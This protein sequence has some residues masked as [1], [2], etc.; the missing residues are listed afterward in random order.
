M[1][2]KCPECELKISS[3]A[4]S[5]PHCGY[6]LRGSRPEN[7]KQRYNPST[8][9]KRLPNG[10]GQISFIKGNLRNPFRAM[11]TVG[12]N[13]SGR[14][15]CKPLKPK[16]YFAT[17][18]DAYAALVEYNKNPY[19]MD[20]S[21]T[22][23]EL[24]NKW[25]D[26]Y[27]ED[28]KSSAAKAIDSAWKYCSEIYDYRVK[29]LRSRHIK[30][31]MENGT[32]NI[33]GN[34]K[35]TPPSVRIRIKSLF[36]MMLDYAVE[37][38]MVEKNCAK[39]FKISKE[40]QSDIVANRKA[41]KAFTDAEMNILWDNAEFGTYEDMILIQ[42][43]S[44]WRPNEL[45]NMRIENVNINEWTFT[46]GSKTDAGK[47]RTVPIHDCIK[48]LVKRRYD[49]AISASSEYLFNCIDA[50]RSNDT[51]LTYSKY[52]KRFKK[53]VPGHSPHDPRKH[54]ITMAKSSGVDEYAIK[55][56]VGHSIRDITEKVYTERDIEWLREEMKKIKGRV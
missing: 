56:L 26:H 37:Y 41:H 8:K 22:V 48:Y 53:I 35:Q 55:H 28:P 6:P 29:E 2:I 9:R 40:L 43:Y 31:V 50:K 42:C 34:I 54:F 12:K 32:I 46:G 13:S 52:Q 11:V 15:I 16:A 18:N 36:N 1:L 14:P 39:S 5:C 10:F 33:K 27:F 20:P 4:Y 17:Y 49:Q 24:Y 38:D 21:I 25:F 19:D 7:I 51:R 23:K 3:K 44:G 45:I 47:N 30:G